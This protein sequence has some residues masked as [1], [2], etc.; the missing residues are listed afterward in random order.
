[1][2]APKP[3]S[4]IYHEARFSRLEWMG[5]CYSRQPP[6]ILLLFTWLQVSLYYLIKRQLFFPDHP[7]DCWSIRTLDREECISRTHLNLLIPNS[8]FKLLPPTS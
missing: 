6:T 3:V 2:Q 8:I 1:M 4:R 7:R 5:T